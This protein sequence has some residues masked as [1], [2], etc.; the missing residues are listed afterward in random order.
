MWECK[1]G[2]RIERRTGTSRKG[3]R[4]RNNESKKRIAGLRT[5]ER[6]TSQ[7]QLSVY[8]P[9]IDLSGQRVKRPFG[10]KEKTRVGQRG[11]KYVDCM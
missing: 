3:G 1:R 7:D 4:W 11:E 8:R 6:I 10:I 2:K 5:H 9:R